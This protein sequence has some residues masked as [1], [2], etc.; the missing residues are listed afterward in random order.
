[1]SLRDLIEADVES[2]F[3][4]T[5]DFAEAWTQWPQGDSGRA[6]SVTVVPDLP[7]TATMRSTR[8]GDEQV[9]RFFIHVAESVA[10]TPKDVWLDE[11]GNQHPTI[12]VGRIDGGMR[13][14]ALQRNEKDHTSRPGA[15]QLL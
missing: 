12:E 9:T 7:L 14:I 6:V 2:V 8:R 13:Q 10:V 3:L 5:D 15:G 4:N 1:M 11:N